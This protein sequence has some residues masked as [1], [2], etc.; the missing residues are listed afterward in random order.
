M[1][2]W[3][4][5]SRQSELLFCVRFLFS[6][7]FAFCYTLQ[8]ITLPY[9][10]KKFDSCHH[11]CYC[12]LDSW[13]YIQVIPLIKK[14]LIWDWESLWNEKPLWVFLNILLIFSCWRELQFLGTNFQEDK[15]WLKRPLKPQNA[16]EVLRW[17]VS[18]SWEGWAVN[19]KEKKASLV[20]KWLLGLTRSLI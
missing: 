17:K 4:V 10:C 3:V 20:K 6:E 12:F 5:A 9:H 16:E 8:T 14:K 11:Y 7:E 2:G 1:I 13:S 18:L 15:C 19:L